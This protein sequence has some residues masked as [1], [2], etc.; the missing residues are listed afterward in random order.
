[1]TRGDYFRNVWTAFR[2]LLWAWSALWNAIYLGRVD[3][4]LSTRIGWS[5]H[6]G[7]FWSRFWFPRWLRA[8][9]K[10]SMRWLVTWE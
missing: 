6:R 2:T 7:E 5:I 3:E 1:M 10:Q 8:H 9:F 4:S